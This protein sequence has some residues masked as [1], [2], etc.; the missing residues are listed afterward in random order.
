VHAALPAAAGRITGSSVA[1]SGRD[2]GSDLHRCLIRRGGIDPGTVAGNRRLNPAVL[3]R[4]AEGS[5]PHLREEQAAPEQGYRPS[6]SKIGR[7][8]TTGVRVSL[9]SNHSGAATDTSL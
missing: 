6:G 1:G 7:G 8:A 3:H 5:H 2:A 9:M 4:T